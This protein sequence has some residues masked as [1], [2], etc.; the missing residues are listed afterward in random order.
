[1]DGFWIGKYEVT[2]IE[3]QRVMGNNLS[4]FKGDR[5]PVEEVSWNDAQEFI[6]RLNA[7]GNGMFRLPTEA[8]WEYAARSGGKDEKYAGGDGVERVA[9]YR[10]NSRGKTHPVGTKAPN[11]LGL[12]DMSGNVWEWCQDWYNKKRLLP[13]CSPESH[14][15]GRR[16]L[17]RLPWRRLVQLRGERP[18][19]Q[20]QQVRP[21]RQALQLRLSPPQNKLAFTF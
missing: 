4:D 15:F 11:C 1:V 2:Q 16:R 3:W 21:G 7:K 13:A 8:E 19:S 12:Y 5:N 20:S 18:G 14:I 17:P 6:K 10:S 9:W